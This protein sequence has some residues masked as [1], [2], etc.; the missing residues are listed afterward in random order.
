MS[1]MACVGDTYNR[2]CD[3]VMAVIDSGCADVV[4]MLMMLNFANCRLK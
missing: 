3:C 1:V 2:A 4:S